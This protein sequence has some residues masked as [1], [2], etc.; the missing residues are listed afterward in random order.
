MPPW[1][2]DQCNLPSSAARFIAIDGL[3]G[4]SSRQPRQPN[5]K[6]TT[7]IGAYSAYDTTYTTYKVLTPSTHSAVHRLPLVDLS[8]VV[9]R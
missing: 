2:L 9:E 4:P 1:L 3:P 8:F 5:D 7:S 6:R